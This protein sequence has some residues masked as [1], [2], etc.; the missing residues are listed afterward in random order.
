[1][2]QHS[3]GI[4]QDCVVHGLCEVEDGHFDV[5][6]LSLAIDSL[7]ASIVTLSLLVSKISRRRA[8]KFVMGVT[9]QLRQL[10]V[11]CSVSSFFVFVGVNLCPAHILYAI[12]LDGSLASALAYAFAR[13]SSRVRPP[14][15]R[16]EKKRYK[17]RP[18]IK[19]R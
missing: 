18:K 6:V 14:R 19:I 12:V 3:S 9:I 4:G 15:P 8:L 16:R 5:V 11:F 2:G 7:M 10:A 1:M 13:S 17:R